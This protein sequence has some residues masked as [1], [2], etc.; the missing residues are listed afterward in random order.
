[1]EKKIFKKHNTVIL[2][3]AFLTVAIWSLLKEVKWNKVH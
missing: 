2:A 3:K 1:M